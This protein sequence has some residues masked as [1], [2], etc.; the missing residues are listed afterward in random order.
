MTQK[1]NRNFLLT[2][3]V[4]IVTLLSSCKSTFPIA[5]STVTC[6]GHILRPIL[7]PTKR[8]SYPSGN[9]AM[10]EFIKSNFKLPQE[11]PNNENHGKVRVVLVVTMEGE[12][13][14][15]RITSKPH[16]YLDNELIRVIKMMPKWIPATN[17]GQNVDSY[18]MLDINF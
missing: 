17:G 14:D 15:V 1:N 13:C 16:K 3:I 8:P 7:N 5:D 9:Q 12:I 4:V 10:L 6:H 18:Y 11:A 2:L